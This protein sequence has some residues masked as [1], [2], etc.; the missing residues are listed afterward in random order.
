M[1]ILFAG[2]AT[3]GKPMK[4]TQL[5]QLKDGIT[6]Q[7]EV[8][9][10]MG[11]PFNKTLTD[12]GEEKWI[13]IYSRSKPTWGSFIPYVGLF[14]SGVVTKGQKLEIIFNE[15][16]IVKKHIFSIPTTTMKTGILQ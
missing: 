9:E 13:Y 2:C 4:E 16:K 3:V 1:L 8:F 6:T 7:E 12:M 14:E 15:K 10:L 5:V 11:E